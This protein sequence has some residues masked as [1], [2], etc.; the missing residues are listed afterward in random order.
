MSSFLLSLAADKTTTGT[1]MVPASVPAGWTGAAATACQ[2]S[3]DDVVALIA[4][5]DTLMTDAQGA[6][7]AYENAKSQEGEN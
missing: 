7:T 3:L 6:M 2:T 1:A 4:G 5:L